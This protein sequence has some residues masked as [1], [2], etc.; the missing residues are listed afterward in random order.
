[1]LSDVHQPHSAARSRARAF[2]YLLL[3]AGEKVAKRVIFVVR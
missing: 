1:V 2:H 3:L